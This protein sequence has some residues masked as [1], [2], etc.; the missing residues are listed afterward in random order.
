MN[1]ANSS[2]DLSG[3][4][5]NCTYRKIKDPTMIHLDSN[6]KHMKQ[7]QVQHKFLFHSITTL[8]DKAK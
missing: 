4:V 2:M 1:I 8:I 5:Q 3:K 6:N 7:K